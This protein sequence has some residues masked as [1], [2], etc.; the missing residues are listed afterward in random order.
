MQLCELAARQAY[1]LLY[2]VLPSELFFYSSRLS[3][4]LCAHCF[5]VMTGGPWL[6]WAWA[7]AAVIMGELSVRIVVPMD[8]KNLWIC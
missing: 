3:F 5:L 8:M 4:I 6:A 1:V 2:S 7:K